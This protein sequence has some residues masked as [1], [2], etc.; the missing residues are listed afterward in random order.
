MINKIKDS[1][2]NNLGH[3]VK[4]LYNGSRNKKEEYAG[5]IK[6]VYDN[7]FIVKLKTDKIKSFSYFDV[8]TNTIEIFFDKI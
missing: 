7:I 8:L 5:I 4:I 1:I 6:E 2:K 3:D